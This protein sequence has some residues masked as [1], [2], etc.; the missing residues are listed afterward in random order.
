[1]EAVL[2]AVNTAPR[3][4]FETLF[5]PVFPSVVFSVNSH[6]SGSR[7]RQ[8][9]GSI[10]QSS[11]RPRKYQNPPSGG[12]VGLYGYSITQTPAVTAT[13]SSSA[14]VCYWRFWVGSAPKHRCNSQFRNA[15]HSRDS[16]DVNLRELV[17]EFGQRPSSSC[18]TVKLPNDQKPASL[19]PAKK[20]TPLD[21]DRR[22]V[23]LSAGQ[24][25]ACNFCEA[26]RG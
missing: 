24:L 22:G 13:N 10:T 17:S 5:I 26:K 9:T 8:R 4:I 19:H 1:M 18:F 15:A 12:E 21:P 16:L 11:Q 20:R 14:S 7:P 2:I 3:I 6:A 25:P 23:L